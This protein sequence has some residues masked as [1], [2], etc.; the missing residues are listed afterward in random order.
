MIIKKANKKAPL[1]KPKLAFIQLLGWRTVLLLACLFVTGFGLSQWLA[2]RASRPLVERLPV[3]VL[4]LLVLNEGRW[5][6]ADGTVLKFVARTTSKDKNRIELKL[7]SNHSKWPTKDFLLLKAQEQHQTYYWLLNRF[8]EREGFSGEQRDLVEVAQ[9]EGGPTFYELVPQYDRKGA[10]KAISDSKK[11]KN[12]LIRAFAVLDLFNA[13]PYFSKHWIENGKLHFSFKRESW[14][15]YFDPISRVSNL[16]PWQSTAVAS[17]VKSVLKTNEDWILYRQ[18]LVK[19]S[20]EGALKTFLDEVRP[21]LEK[22]AATYRQILDN[23]PLESL[24]AKI[25]ESALLIRHQNLW[26]IA[27]IKATLQESKEGRLV[28]KAANRRVFPVEIKSVRFKGRTAFPATG[29]TYFLNGKPD[30]GVMSFETLVFDFKDPTLSIPLIERSLVQLEYNLLGGDKTYLEE[31]IPYSQFDEG[32]LQNDPLLSMKKD[33]KQAAFV[34]EKNGVLILQ[35]GRWKLKKELVFPQGYVV[36]AEPGFEVD[37]TSGAGIISFSPVQFL[38][39]ADKPIRFFSSDSTGQG[40]AVISAETESKLRY[41]VFENLGALSKNQWRLTSAVTFYESPVVINQS[42]FIKNRAEDSLSVIRTDFVLED[43]FFD[44][45]RGNA[46]DVDF[47]KGKITKTRFLNSKNTSVDLAGSNVEIRQSQIDKTGNVA[48][49]A[50]EGSIVNVSDVR[51]SEAKLGLVSKD[52][53]QLSF[54]NV[55]IMNS[56]IGISVYRQNDIFAQSMIEG[57]KIEMKQT[58]K[59]TLLEYGSLVT[60]DGKRLL[61]DQKNLVNVIYKK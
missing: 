34:K 45:A 23:Y 54:E 12:D 13:W 60:I 30:K 59:Q 52:S 51:I 48:I 3:V 15:T 47:G 5:R 56:E 29:K 20:R 43:S 28:L 37:L 26:P 10:I 55:N 2:K 22:V 21:E 36:Q 16:G 61:G 8:L 27:N 46:V 35:A 17:W 31:I 41:V 18:E 49:S 1:K 57:R 6:T 58:Q 33:F 9:N 24:I 7:K 14:V 25:H 40:F 39:K 53:S 38:G 42:R 44:D 32:L 19:F 50:G 4:D 11:Y